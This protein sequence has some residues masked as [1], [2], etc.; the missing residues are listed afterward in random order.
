MAKGVTVL[1]IFLLACLTVHTIV[2]L[3]LSGVLSARSGHY[4]PYLRKMDQNGLHVGSAVNLLS[5]GGSTK[6][7][8][9]TALVTIFNKADHDENGMLGK[10]EL[11]NYIH[12]TLLKHLSKSIRDNFDRYFQID[13]D[14][15]NGLVS[16]DEYVYHYFLLKGISG[17][18]SMDIRNRTRA[19]QELPREIKVDIARL[20]ASWS[21][22]SSNN[23]DFLTVD[24]FLQFEHPE[25]SPTKTL[26]RVQDILAIFDFDGDGVITDREFSTT[27]REAEGVDPVYK[28]DKKLIDTDGDGQIT[29]V[30]LMRYE[31]PRNIHH[32][33][34]EA[35]F[36]MMTADKD[37]DGKLTL[38][39]VVRNADIFV[40][41]KF[42][43]ADNQFHA[44]S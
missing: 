6:Q 41:S 3:G 26:A 25:A 17:I 31:D 33:E 21:E 7:S 24:E 1:F 5:P 35:R 16:W 34:K 10:K 8:T 11:A 38:L 43:N 18:T 19:F 32:S 39:E 22:S 20:Q 14:P 4:H 27:Y 9:V 28:Y 37:Q 12:N 36:L 40:K 42:F 2:D 23:P 29:R 13:T 30:E 44:T 15:R